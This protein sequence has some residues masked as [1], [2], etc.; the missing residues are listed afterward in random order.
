MD[1]T[2]SADVRT[3]KGN[4]HQN[5]YI[6]SFFSCCFC[7]LH[8][9]SFSAV[10]FFVFFFQFPCFRFSLRACSL[11]S[12]P[13]RG[14]QGAR[15]VVLAAIRIARVLNPSYSLHFASPGH[16]IRSA[17]CTSHPQAAK[18]AALLALRSTRAPNP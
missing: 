4:V 7:I 2:A 10:F 8:R 1:F 3:K 6:V 15:S 11:F 18:S 9:C 14:S 5:Q 16:Q 13:V 12:V 17:R